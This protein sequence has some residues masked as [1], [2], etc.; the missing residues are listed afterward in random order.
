M[1]L[2]EKEVTKMETLEFYDLVKKKKFKTNKYHY[3]HRG[4][5]KFAV[6]KDS[7]SGNECWRV[8]GK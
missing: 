4:G 2:T 8:L 5:R 3:A 7:P 6:T 1:D